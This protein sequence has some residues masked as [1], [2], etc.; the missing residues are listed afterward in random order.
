METVKLRLVA[1]ISVKPRK[2]Q[3]ATEAA[4]AKLDAFREAALP[5][6]EWGILL[7]EDEAGRL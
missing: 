6:Q 3:S 2:G 1:E 5:S 7:Y 4:R